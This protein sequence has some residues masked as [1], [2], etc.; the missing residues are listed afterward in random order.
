LSTIGIVR[1]CVT[2]GREVRRRRAKLGNQRSSFIHKTTGNQNNKQMG[3]KPVAHQ[4]KCAHALTI[5]NSAQR[6]GGNRGLNTQHIMREIKTR[7][8]RRQDKT[9]GK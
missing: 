3:T 9:N 7:C 4:R 8:V 5:N 1:D 2:G 6:Y